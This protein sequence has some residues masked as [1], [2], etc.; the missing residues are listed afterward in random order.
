MKRNLALILPTLLA[1][2]TLISCAGDDGSGTENSSQDAVTRTIAGTSAIGRPGSWSNNCLNESCARAD[3]SGNYLLAT[4]VAGN[5]LMY[6]DI[7]FSDGSTT[8]LYSRYRLDEDITTTLVNIN[9]STHAIL[10]I[11]STLNH[12]QAIDLCSMDPVCET[13]LL[14]SFT[15]DIEDTIVNQF[16]ALLGDAWPA[17]R[18]PF[19]DVYIADPDV[20]ALDLMHD[21]LQFVISNRDLIIF[22]NLGNEISRASLNQLTQSLNLGNQVLS[23]AT[24]NDALQLPP[25]QPV[26]NGITLSASITPSQ[27]TTAPVDLTVNVSRSESTYGDLSFVHNLTVP[28]GVT[29]EFT[30]D[31]VSTTLTEGG[32][33]IWVVTATDTTGL[34]R[35]QGYVITVLGGENDEPAFGGEGSCTTPESALTANTQNLCIES[36]NGSELGE[37]DVITTSSVSLVT[38]PAPCAHQTQNEGDLLGVCTVLYNETRVFNYE[39]PLRPNFAETFEEKQA[40]LQRH[41]VDIIEGAWATS[42]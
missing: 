28:S 21:H 5:T 18:N 9:P 14:A 8:R 29:T 4:T 7:P 32:S 23:T 33:N 16:D 1:T 31:I 30:G 2:L 39:N 35:T 42:P 20:D 10:D 25:E 36:Q 38:S 6:S 3:E 40:R 22:D 11:W 17:G 19:D 15:T 24:Y 26:A 37:C 27:A 34:S 41:C 13:Q 12:G